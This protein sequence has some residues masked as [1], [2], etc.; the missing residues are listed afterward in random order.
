MA[1]THPTAEPE[2][3][4][5]GPQSDGPTSSGPT[6]SGATSNKFFEWMRQLDTPRQQGWIGGVAAGLATRLRIDPI[7][8]R[9]ILVVA[10]ILGAPVILLYAVAWLLLPDATGKIH[11][12]EV[13]RGRFEAPLAGIAAMLVV[14]LLP[15]SRGFWVPWSGW[16]SGE[17]WGGSFFGWFWTLALLA[18][19]IWFIIWIARRGDLPPAPNLPPLKP[20][21]VFPAA[22]PTPPPA[23]AQP[24]DLAAWRTQQAQFKAE[25][26]QWRNEQAHQAHLEMRERNRAANA[27]A[28]ADYLEKRAATKPSTLFTLSVVGV[29]L[30]AGALTVL[31]IGG[32]TPTLADIVPGL[33][34]SLAVLAFGIIVNGVRGKRSGGASPIALL[35]VFVLVVSSFVPSIPRFT[36]SGDVDLAPSNRQITGQPWVVADGDL[37][38][39]LTKVYTSP[40]SNAEGYEGENFNA[41]VGWGDVTII[42]PADEYVSLR[43]ETSGDSQV[44]LPDVDGVGTGGYET[45]GRFDRQSYYEQYSINDDVD[46]NDARRS[47]YVDVWVG[48]GNVTIVRAPSTATTE[49]TN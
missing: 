46:W 18:S 10:A 15:V 29:A 44:T 14:A 12:E 24:E 26:N 28:R 45:N 3:S 27:A 43:V 48:D 20:D 25:H 35:V 49:E 31:A 6:P 4:A 16:D 41:Y 11:L 2:A 39:D 42:L 21:S 32:E 17:L 22:E 8:V 37:T 19:V 7:I 13:T 47:I 38:A 34:V 40:V 9:G 1:S 30:I 5:P 23:D 33:I 36:V